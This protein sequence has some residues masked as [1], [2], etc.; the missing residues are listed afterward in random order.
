MERREGQEL[1]WRAW[2][3]PRLVDESGRLAETGGNPVFPPALLLA[4]PLWP[5]GPL[6][7][8]YVVFDFPNGRNGNQETL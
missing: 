8:G 3:W 5:S 4:D 2:V 7:P 1:C 6:S